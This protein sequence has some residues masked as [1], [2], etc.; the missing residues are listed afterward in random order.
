M[1]EAEAGTG[2]L[3]GLG[4][5]FELCQA[6]VLLSRVADSSAPAS[7]QGLSFLA[8]LGLTVRH[9]PYLKLGISF[10]FI[11]AAIQV[12]LGLGSGHTDPV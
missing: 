3:L 6:R 4:F 8:G 2:F 1:W 7:G 11:S 12:P 5:G 9:P 10:L